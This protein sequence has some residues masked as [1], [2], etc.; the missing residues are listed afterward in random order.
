M[1]PLLHDGER[2]IVDKLTYRL[3][4]IRRGDVVVF[5]YP[6]DPAVSF[7]KRIVALPGETIELDRGVLLID[8]HAV[9]EDYIGTASR[10]R[11]SHRPTRVPPGHYFV[12]GDHRTSSNDSRSWGEV[13]Q[14]YI[15]GRA[16]FRFWP[17]SKLGAIP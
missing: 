13:P 9:R 16:L 12:M 14:K 6:R 4:P 2:I 11:A 10:D 8:G 15:Y 5:W 17:P 7:I 1:L 3:E